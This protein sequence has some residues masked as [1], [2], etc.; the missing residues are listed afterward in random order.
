MGKKLSF[1]D[2][3]VVKDGGDDNATLNATTDNAPTSQAEE[4][5]TIVKVAFRRESSTWKDDESIRPFP[6]KTSDLPYGAMISLQIQPPPPSEQDKVDKAGRTF[7]AEVISW[8]ILEDPKQAAEELA[9][10]GQNYGGMLYS[11]YLRERGNSFWTTTKGQRMAKELQDQQQ[12]QRQQN[13]ED[14][15]NVNPLVAKK[16]PRVGSPLEKKEDKHPSVAASKLASKNGAQIDSDN[17]DLQSGGHGDKVAKNMRARLFAQWLL[18]TYGASSL[19]EGT[20]V[21]DVAGGKGNLSIELAATGKVPCVVIDPMIR[22]QQQSFPVKRDAKRIRKAGG[23]LPRH[24]P[25]FFNQTTFLERYGDTKMESGKQLLLELTINTDVA[26]T[27]NNSDDD[28]N[29]DH[30]LV[31]NSS[32]LVGLHPDQTTQDILELAL[33]YDKN[34]AIVPCCVFPSY[35]PLRLLR[36]GTPVVTHAQFCQYLLESDPSLQQ[37]ELPFQGRN[38]VIYRCKE[39]QRK[40]PCEQPG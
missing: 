9:G 26:T 19:Q 34:V 27:R 39:S 30:D 14:S 33:R 32:M 13:K 23:P 5:E 36:D 15:D 1:A 4:D 11:T 3:R 29:P 17:D 20:G 2:V 21:L 7:P 37:T 6:I 25:T 16:R 35:F 22:K 10:E 28:Y 8:Q 24:L 31:S 18:D 38:V 40:Q 12:Q